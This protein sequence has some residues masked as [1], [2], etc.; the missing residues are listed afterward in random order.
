MNWYWAYSKTGF[1][2]EVEESIKGIG[3]DC[4][5]GRKMTF[6]RIGKRRRPEPVISP[7]LLNYVF[8]N[9]PAEKFHLVQETRHLYPTFSCLTDMDVRDLWRFRNR[10]DSEYEAA[11]WISKNSDKALQEYAE[12]QMLVDLSGRF[13]EKCL[14]YRGMV[15]RA[16]DV[17]PKIRASVKMM[18][19]EVIVE[20]DPLQVKAAK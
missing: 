11:L 2:F 3:V 13:G 7:K 17:Y 20:L 8:I 12:G 16:H 15:E 14:E 5:V 10:V 6:N 19:R 9:M 1:E 18:N 4:W